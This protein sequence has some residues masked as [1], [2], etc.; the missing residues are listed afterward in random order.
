MNTKL[1]KEVLDQIENIHY[2]TRIPVDEIYAQIGLIPTRVYP[3]G[4]AI[5]D[6]NP[7]PTGMFRVHAIQIYDVKK[8]EPNYWDIYVKSLTNAK[9]CYEAGY[10]H[11]NECNCNV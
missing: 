7:T 1:P 6:K 5:W 4:I 9:R 3:D 10:R 2:H 11:Y 8:N